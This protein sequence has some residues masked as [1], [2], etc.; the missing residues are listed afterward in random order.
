MGPGLYLFVR[1]PLL[2]R[3]FLNG[4]GC[5]VTAMSIFQKICP[6]CMITLPLDTHVCACG[7]PFDH[8]DTEGSLSSEEI[9]VKAEELY[10]SYL[11]A[12]V[13]QATGS[14]MSA[15][16]EF[17]R[18]PES[19]VKSQ[20]VADAIQESEAARVALSEQSARVRE[21]KKALP[22]VSPPPRPLPLPVA[23]KKLPTQVITD[24][25]P[26]RARTMA[27]AGMF[28]ASLPI[29]AP[30]RS[31]QITRKSIPVP[32]KKKLVPTPVT[33]SPEDLLPPVQ[34]K[35]PN[36]TFRQAQAAKAE[37][38]LRTERKT[39]SEK[40]KNNNTQI[41][42]PKVK[43]ESLPP[44]PV[45]TKSAPRLL[46]SDKKECPNCT[47][48]VESKSNRCRCGFEFSSS[49]QLIPALSMSEEER[50]EFAKI[51]TLP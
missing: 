31:K 49:E 37:K 41:D 43:P 45:F 34:S 30:V 11:A 42:K 25:A 5:P 46:A 33:I 28:A 14:V 50:A 51:F 10:E 7:H 4:Q 16:A 39:E 1:H 48:S 13:E 12:R 35:T 24:P 29:S 3:K 15:Q 44:N 21:L 27:R 22:A 8:D 18:D 23:P 40:P 20:R 2:Q 6:G 47:A 9:R 17:A 36:T 19:P 32:H 38:F 26:T